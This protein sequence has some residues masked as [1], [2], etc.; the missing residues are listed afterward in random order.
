MRIAILSAVLIMLCMPLA[1]QTKIAYV[2]VDSLLT[3]CIQCKDAESQYQEAIAQWDAELQAMADEL[4]ELKA[5]LDMPVSETRKKEIQ[6]DY[7]EKNTAFEKKQV[8][9]YG[10]EGKAMQL[11]FE[12]MM[13]LLDHIQKSMEQYAVDNDIQVI[14]DAETGEI[15]Y[16]AANVEPVDATGIILDVVNTT[17]LGE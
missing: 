12:L 11:N 9:I 8:E 7:D 3:N 6:A 10:Q 17:P 13:P 5:Q 16:M 14:F 2:D 15:L 1:A 4:D